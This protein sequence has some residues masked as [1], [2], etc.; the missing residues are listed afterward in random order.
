M[1]LPLELMPS[2]SL[3][4]ECGLL[5]SLPLLVFI[6]PQGEYPSTRKANSGFLMYLGPGSMKVPNL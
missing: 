2:M 6:G 3:V 1:D 4:L 5:C